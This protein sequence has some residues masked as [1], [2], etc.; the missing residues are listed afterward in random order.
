M[1]NNLPEHT[2]STQGTVQQNPSQKKQTPP[3][4]IKAQ[5]SVG[6]WEEGL[7]QSTLQR[8][9]SILSTA[10]A[11]SLVDKQLHGILLNPATKIEVF[12]T[13]DVAGAKAEILS[14]MPEEM[15]RSAQRWTKE[16]AFTIAIRDNNSVMS[17][18]R[19]ITFIP[20]DAVN[21][22]SRAIGLL[23]HELHHVSAIENQEMKSAVAD[24]QGEAVVTQRSIAGLKAIREKL[25]E[26]PAMARI[27]A[28]L[29]S[30]I[31]KEQ[32]RL[33]QNAK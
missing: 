18:L 3:V 26:S 10:I 1:S 4:A 12:V 7:P 8:N 15:R 23:N 16:D 13:K 24:R 19:Y 32:E 25:A 21:D 17:R 30:F 5:I 27:V 22:L 20:A 33:R 6:S 28:S 11:A 2:L 14:K 29:G 9:G 31:T